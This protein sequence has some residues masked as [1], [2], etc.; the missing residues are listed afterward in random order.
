MKE[1]TQKYLPQFLQLLDKYTG[2][3]LRNLSKK[4]EF[5]SMIAIRGLQLPGAM[6]IC[7]AVFIRNRLVAAIPA[8][9]PTETTAP[10]TVFAWV[11]SADQ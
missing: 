6:A 9:D 4:S 7:Y 3:V 1:S 2:D 10:G 11:S 8:A 5:A